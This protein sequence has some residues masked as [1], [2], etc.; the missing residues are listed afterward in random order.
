MKFTKGHETNIGRHHSIETKK[1]IGDALRGR[2][3]TDYPLLSRSW[4]EEQKKRF[5]PW[6]K[7]RKHTE[8]TRRKMLENQTRGESNHRWKD[9]RSQIPGY[10]N[11]LK[12]RYKQ[13]KKAAEGSHTFREWCQLKEHNGYACIV[14]GR[15]EPE[16]KLTED[17]VIPLIRGGTDYINNI[18]PLCAKC[19]SCKNSK[20]MEE[21]VS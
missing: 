16:I 9:G 8:E 3:A 1:K 14:C 5:V 15:K 21:F 10:M 11:W 4:T 19:N 18:Q 13:R 20:T 7:G 12:N 2:S 17:H 6:I